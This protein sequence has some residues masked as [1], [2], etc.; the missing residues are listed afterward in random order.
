MVDRQPPEFDYTLRRG[1][2]SAYGRALAS[3]MRLRLLSMVVSVALLVL[4]VAVLILS[5]PF[6]NAIVNILAV[7]LTL[8]IS[9]GPW[10]VYRYTTQH[11]VEPDL[12]FRMWLQQVCDGELDARI[13]LPK[14]HRHYKELNF[15]TRNLA[16]SLRRLSDDM[17]E[18][19]ESQ[20]TRLN[21]QKRVLEL[22]FKITA[23]VASESE[24]EA[25]FTTVVEHL[26]EWFDAS[27][28]SCYRV[29][30]REDNLRC[31][32]VRVGKS[33]I[34]GD[35]T[36]EQPE[37]AQ[38][39]FD[40]IPSRITTLNLTSNGETTQN[41]VPFFAGSDPV[42]VLIIELEKSAAMQRIETRRVL[43]T[44]SEQLSLLCGKQLVHEQMLKARL[45][46]DRNELAAEIHDS[47]A[48]TLLAVRYQTTLLG[49]KLKAN[50]DLESY[51]D[52]QK[53]TNSIEEANEEIRGLIR[54]NR[55]PLSEHRYADSLQETIDQF[56]QSSGLPVFF[57][58]DDPHIRFIPREESVLQRIIG[59]ALNNARKYAEASM[60]RV[61]LQ[62]G[63]SGVR[64]VLIED[65]G[66][67]FHR[68]AYQDHSHLAVDDTGSQIG[69]T[70]MWERALSIGA[71]LTI[72][73]EPGEGTRIAITMPPLIESQR[74]AK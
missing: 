65:D 21:D 2:I 53:I 66:V 24:D 3:S 23:E 40:E 60:I 49:E 15:H 54:Q 64:R 17:D 16:S 30:S 35:A 34:D 38:I 1:E 52:V 63:D 19:V 70:I 69:L 18:L 22:L 62:Q 36:R 10:L 32:A 61:Y 47:L 46:H 28:V 73:S 8:L 20:T 13:D 11:F 67:G 12:A 72:D 44:V 31:V 29:V 42:G 71:K 6:A 68:S 51:G 43:S 33:S 55:S 74:G 56:S 57:Q 50:A 27:S 39:A 41:W 14:D 7:L 59:E 45:S 25:A 37:C 26:A 9:V 5:W 48:Q 4:W 58:S